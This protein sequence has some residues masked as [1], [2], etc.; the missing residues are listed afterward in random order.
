MKRPESMDECAYF[1]NRDIGEKG[2]ARVWVFRETCPKCKKGMMG[3]PID[4]KTGKFKTRSTEYICPECN[5]SVEKGEYEDTLTANIEYTCPECEHE[6]E[7][8]VPFK[9]K[10]IKGIE[11][12]RTNCEKCGANIDITKKMKEK[13]EK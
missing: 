9:R 8:Q 12:L 6:G 3:K 10:K 13:G 1:T 11:T 7:T 2:S 5:Y 4:S